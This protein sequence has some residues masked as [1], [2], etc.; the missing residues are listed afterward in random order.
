[1]TESKRSPKTECKQAWLDYEAT[2]VITDRVPDA[3]WDFPIDRPEKPEDHTKIAN[4]GLKKA[5]RKFPLLTK[6]QI[7]KYEALA[8]S[9]NPSDRAEYGEFFSREWDRRLNGFFFYNGDV[10][11]WITGWNYVWLQ[12]W[13]IAGLDPN[14]N[15]MGEIRPAFRDAQRDMFYI[16]GWMTGQ[17]KAAG[18]IWL[19][20]R[21]YGKS[22][23]SM[24]C[25]LM[26]TSENE[27]SR[28]PVQH[29]TKEDGEKSFKKFIIDGWKKLPIWYK[30]IDTGQT[31]YKNHIVFGNQMKK[32]VDIADRTDTYAL[33]SEIFVMDSK[34]GAVDGDYYTWF[35]RDEAAKA[36]KHIDIEESWFVTREA[37]FIGARK[38]G[39]SILTS[40]AEDMEKYGAAQ[41][42]SLWNKSNPKK[43]LSSGFTESYLVPIFIPAYYGFLD[44]EDE[45]N[46][47][48][49]DTSKKFIDEWGYSNVEVCKA[50]HLQIYS[51]L[52]GNSLLSRKRKY[53]VTFGDA[54]LRGDMRN[55]FPISNL[56]QQKIHNDHVKNYVRGNFEWLHGVKDS[57]VIW[58]PN[59]LGKCWMLASW[60]TNENDRNKYEQRGLYRYPSREG[61]YIGVDPFSH[62]ATVEHGSMGAAIA[63][64][65]YDPYAPKI[66]EAVVC[67]YHYREKEPYDFAEDVLMQ[68]VFMGAK[69]MVERNIHGFIDHIKQRGY[70]GYLMKDPLEKDPKKL[71]GADY[72][73]PNKDQDKREAL[74]SITSSF[75]RDRLGKMDDGGYGICPFNTLLD[76]CIEFE[77]QS[78]TKYDLVVAFML[79]VT[80]MRVTRVVERQEGNINQWVPNLNKSA[81][82]KVRVIKQALSRIG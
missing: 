3:I 60:M 80:A 44:D 77:A 48:L 9:S 1:M 30:P 40:T 33:D 16:I 21:R 19:S 79:A 14:T 66:K 32:G 82:H 29:K 61:V 70:E 23:I 62:T 59:D 47:K 56:I 76:Q 68:A 41:F 71:I 67:M 63:V 53:P 55:T 74:M 45:D 25:G 28:F 65:K 10:L 26:D 57:A 38:V 75:M 13:W 22:A 78:W 72:G 34:E 51:E 39:N 12:Y 24:F 4:Y 52:E 5:E 73:F 64:V 2:Y 31:A 18:I 37:S 20:F 35:V 27:K 50:Y 81:E 49:I 54:W 11:E 6:K 15:R 43:R 8:A 36:L 7:A 46:E 17:K 58:R 69:I 42:L